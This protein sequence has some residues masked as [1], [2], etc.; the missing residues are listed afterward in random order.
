MTP[1]VVYQQS[2]PSYVV[3]W[4]TK[5]TSVLPEM[6]P[7]TPQ[8][9]TEYNELM[10]RLRQLIGVADS[11]NMRMLTDAEQTWRQP[12]IDYITLDLFRIGNQSKPIIFNTYQCYLTETLPKLQRH[13]ETAMKEHFYLGVKIVR[14]AYIVAESQRALELNYKNPIVSSKVSADSNYNAG[15]SFLLGEIAKNKKI[16]MVIAT[17][18]LGSVIRACQKIREQRLPENHSDIHFAQLKGMAD[19]LTLGLSYTNFNANKLLP[20]GPVKAVI[21]YL[22]RRLQENRDILGGTMVERH[23]IWKELKN[24]HFG[25]F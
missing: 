12:A 24:R 3:P 5:A 15:V 14:G 1:H 9:I 16:S 19:H 18:N 23:L 11:S 7:F 8:D 4:N 22:T 6:E 25:L 17:H 13:Y 21:P 10:S 20:Y 2:N